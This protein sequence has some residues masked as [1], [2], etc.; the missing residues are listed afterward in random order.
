MTEQQDSLVSDPP[1]RILSWLCEKPTKG[2]EGAAYEAM[3]IADLLLKGFE[4]YRSFGPHSKADLVAR[5]C[6]VTLF[7]EVRKIV[8]SNKESNR[9]SDVRQKHDNCDVYGVVLDGKVQYL[10]KDYSPYRFGHPRFGQRGR[11]GNASISHE[12]AQEG[13]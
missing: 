9:L 4:V 3:V 2:N 1:S 8:W 11:K 6:G 10:D 7:I 13:T 12:V 5:G